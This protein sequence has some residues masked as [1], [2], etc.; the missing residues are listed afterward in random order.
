M[1]R[2]HARRR[3][4]TRALAASYPMNTSLEAHDQY[5]PFEIVILSQRPSWR[6]L[7]IVRRD[8]SMLRAAIAAG[9]AIRL[10]EVKEPSL[11]CR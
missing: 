6:S 1:G 5:T 4:F 3:V 7:K 2:Y 11:I 9:S 8:G 10:T